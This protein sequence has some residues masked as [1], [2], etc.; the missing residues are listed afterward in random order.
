[1][2][3]FTVVSDD[4]LEPGDPIR[5]IDIIAIKN[6]TLFLFDASFG[7]PIIN[8]Q[9]FDASG[10]WTR[11]SISS[12]EAATVVVVLVG[13][14]GGGAVQSRVDPWTSL[15]ANQRNAAC[16]GGG[17]GG[18]AIA[19]ALYNETNT[20]STITIGAGATPRSIGTNSFSNGNTGGTTTFAMTAG[21]INAL[22]GQGGFYQDLSGAF[23]GFSSTPDGGPTGGVNRTGVW[24]DLLARGS[25][26]RG[27]NAGD[28]ALNTGRPLYSGGGAF[29][30]RSG[31]TFP[32]NEL[33]GPAL[34][35][36]SLNNEPFMGAGG[37]GSTSTAG[38]GQT[39]GGGGGGAAAPSGSVT[40]GGGGAGGA[41]VFVVRGLI[42]SS[43][44]NAKYLQIP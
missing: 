19:Y 16:G 2:S 22:G 6:N 32:Q 27:I 31:I 25:G 29:A 20:T 42:T 36:V 33:G 13:G 38:N 35:L 41:L 1:M 4:V 37:I 23:T 24:L 7:F 17:S 15:T 3:D 21:N 28:P 39:F 43:A 18:I 9:R 26:G 12:P 8:Q 34:P 44:F 14:G 10:T 30:A 40:G 11:P 5:S